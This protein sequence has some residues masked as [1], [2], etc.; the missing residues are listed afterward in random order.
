MNYKEEFQKVYSYA[1]C[2][3]EGPF[4]YMVL[5]YPDNAYNICEELCW[6]T[7]YNMLIMR[8]LTK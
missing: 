3:K 6:E 7:A 5:M 8:T 1:I 4:K 2:Y